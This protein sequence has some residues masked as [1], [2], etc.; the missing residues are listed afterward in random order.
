MR[1]WRLVVVGCCVCGWQVVVAAAL[2]VFARVK[3]TLNLAV[4]AGDQRGGQFVRH[5]TKSHV[6]NLQLFRCESEGDRVHFDS[7]DDTRASICWSALIIGAMN[8]W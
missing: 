4:D 8:W 1:A 2:F 6:E 7:K 5:I 3:L